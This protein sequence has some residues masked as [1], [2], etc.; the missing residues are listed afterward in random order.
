M[1]IKKLPI[2]ILYVADQTKSTEF[3]SKIL[4]SSP[5]LN[6]PGM[7][8]F[9]LNDLTKIGLMPEKGIERIICPVMPQP[10]KGSGIPRCEL[11]I[12]V[13]DPAA[14]LTNAIS[15]GA[16]EISKA[17]MRDWGDVVAYC[18]DPDGNIIAFA[19]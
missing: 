11:Y 1:A 12:I 9:M 7:T 8:E 19:K 5:V 13:D 16:I 3:Y 17:G 14:S 2:I 6:V 18:S 4:S 10:V 15:A